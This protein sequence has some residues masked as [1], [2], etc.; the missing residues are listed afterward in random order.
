MKKGMVLAGL[1]LTLVGCSTENHLLDPV[2]TP[3][4]ET[5]PEPRDSGVRPPPVPPG[6]RLETPRL[7]GYPAWP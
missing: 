3:L 1:L 2:H 6:T 7:R 4:V 5:S